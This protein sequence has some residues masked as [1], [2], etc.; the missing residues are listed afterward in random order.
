V[1]V[2]AAFRCDLS[3]KEVSA[4]RQSDRALNAKA[5][6]RWLTNSI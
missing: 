5:T 1:V 2:K 6:D 4:L 3:E